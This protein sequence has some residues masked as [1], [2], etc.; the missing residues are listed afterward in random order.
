MFIKILMSEQIKFC[1]LL[2]AITHH[3]CYVLLIRLKEI[4]ILYVNCTIQVLI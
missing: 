2:S 4:F 1:L 3:E